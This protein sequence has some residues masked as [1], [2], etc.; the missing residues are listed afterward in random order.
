MAYSSSIRCDEM[1]LHFNLLMFERDRS[2]V[3]QKAM[4]LA[5]TKSDFL[6]SDAWRVRLRIELRDACYNSWTGAAPNS[7]TGQGFRIGYP[8]CPKGEHG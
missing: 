6:L 4:T 2:A 3:D 8:I 5:W 1:V 7:S